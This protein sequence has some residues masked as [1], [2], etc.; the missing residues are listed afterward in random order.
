MCDDRIN[1]YISWVEEAK[2]KSELIDV[3]KDIKDDITLEN[4]YDDDD[5]DGG[6]RQFTKK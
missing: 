3:L 5:E 6:G 2:T 1:E 4:E